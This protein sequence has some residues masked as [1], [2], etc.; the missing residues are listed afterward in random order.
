MWRQPDMVSMVERAENEADEPK[1]DTPNG[2]RYNR[3]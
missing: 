2:T 1:I 3:G